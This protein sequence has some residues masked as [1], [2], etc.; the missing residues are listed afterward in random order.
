PY[1]L[2]AMQEKAP[3]LEETSKDRIR[4][5]FLKVCND[6][7]LVHF[8]EE[9]KRIGIQHFVMPWFDGLDDAAWLQGVRIWEQFSK[10]AAPEKISPDMGL[11]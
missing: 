7:S 2:E 1:L 10:M 6:R 4:E 5:E 3:L 9:I 11:A 8:L